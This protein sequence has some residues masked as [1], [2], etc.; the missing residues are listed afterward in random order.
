[1]K[2]YWLLLL[3]QA[4]IIGGVFAQNDPTPFAVRADSLARK[5]GRLAPA[6]IEWKKDYAITR[7]SETAGSIAR[8]YALSGE[9][10][11]AFNWLDIALAHD[12]T[13]NVLLDDQLFPL[14]PL[15]RWADL[16]ARQ[17]AKITAQPSNIRNVQLA[18]QLWRLGMKDQAFSYEGNLSNRLLGLESPVS[19]AVWLLQQKNREE[20]LQEIKQII[21]ATGWPRKSD[22][23]ED[24]AQVAFYVVQHSDVAAQEAFI[25]LLK[26]ACETGEGNCR[27]YAT[28]YDRI[29]INNGKNQFYGTQYQYK[30]VNGARVL[31]L[32]PI[33]SPEFVDKRRRSMGLT[34]PFSKQMALIGI[35]FEVPQKD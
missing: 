34:W 27:D 26:S 35:I 32:F 25:P 24:A 19:K 9:I 20:N 10:D 33:E 11:S 18:R 17:I 12:S 29:L 31:D 22:V 2:K 21:R 15:P 23:G 14:V 3:M 5:A 6:I 7:Q 13:P 8:S 16:E 4:A 28:M 30:T 1:M